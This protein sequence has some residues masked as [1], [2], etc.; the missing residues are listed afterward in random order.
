MVSN[1]K[2]KA[3]LHTNSNFSKKSSFLPLTI[4]D[5][6]RGLP[7]ITWGGSLWE[8][9][10]I[11]MDR[12]IGSHMSQWEEEL[13]IDLYRLNEG[14]IEELSGG[15]WLKWRKA[16]ANTE[17]IQRGIR[18]KKKDIMRQLT[19][20]DYGDT[21]IGKE[22]YQRVLRQ[23]GRLPV[24]KVG[25]EYSR[26]A[27]SNEEL[28]SYFNNHRRELE[29]ITKND[30]L[31]FEAFVENFLVRLSFTP[32]T[33][34]THNGK[35]LGISVPVYLLEDVQQWIDEEQFDL[36]E[37]TFQSGLN[38]RQMKE[39]QVKYDDAVSSALISEED[40]IK[41][42]MRSFIE[43]LIQNKE[44]E[45]IYNKNGVV[46]K[47]SLNTYHQIVSFNWV[48]FN[49][50]YEGLGGVDLLED[51]IKS[52]FVGDG[53]DVQM[54]DEG[55]F[56]SGLRTI[57]NAFFEEVRNEKR[58]EAWGQLKVQI[59]TINKVWK[60]NNKLSSLLDLL[61]NGEVTTKDVKDYVG[62]FDFDPAEMK[63]FYDEILDEVNVEKHLKTSIQTKR[64]IKKVKT[65]NRDK[66]TGL[67]LNTQMTTTYIFKR[68]G[69][70]KLNKEID[71]ILEGHSAFSTV[72]NR[73]KAYVKLKIK[74]KF[75]KENN[76]EVDQI[77]G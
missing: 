9:M 61:K 33:T 67:P 28:L 38:A 30:E 70:D 45:R 51:S 10:S 35:S 62:R 74:Q 16:R 68:N 15:L 75:A 42:D 34:R 12:V 59:E 22:E 11:K 76:I 29:Q 14:E 18:G 54:V 77:I 72:S 52:E 53:F 66:T 8:E 4:T 37:A 63:S 23:H 7:A 32:R 2:G 57:A 60:S 41:E 43:G 71:D 31:S 26:G 24:E 1:S 36:S 40:P 73:A 5:Q 3:M 69:K 65:K 46:L 21:S 13:T 55:K 27:Y 17:N 49:S 48:D 39:L 58:S 19:E 20:A 64:K 25:V 56:K 50:L 44:K 6:I 47:E